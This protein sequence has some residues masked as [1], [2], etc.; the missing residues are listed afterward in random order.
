MIQKVNNKNEYRCIICDKEYASKSSLCNHNK[1]FHNELKLNII[2]PTKPPDNPIIVPTNKKYLCTYCNYEFNHVQNRWRHEQKCKNTHINLQND[3]NLIKIKELELKLKKQETKIL[4][5]KLKIQQSNSVDNN[6]INKL[7]KLLTIRNNLIKN[8][9]INSNNNNT[10]NNIVNNN[11][12]LVGF[13]KEDI[14]ELLTMQEKKQIINAKYSCLE[15]LVEITHCGKYN[16]F[17]NILITNMKD[18]YMYKYDE[19]NGQFVLANKKDVLDTLID[20]RVNDLETIYDD[21]TDNNKINDKTKEIIENVIDK[22]NNTNLEYT[23]ENYKKVFK[24]YKEYKTDEIKVLLFNNR[25]KT[26]EDVTL[27]LTA[28]EILNDST[29]E[30]I[31]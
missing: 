20:H 9:N 30:I 6:S 13:G 16:Q 2:T 15:K 31:L 7:N 29:N 28:E 1:K 19:T 18:N 27:L 8:S 10:Q 26:V 22:I 24:N 4:Q 3:I 5:Y 12:Q 11:F 14:T 17:K 23:N 25:N 21:I